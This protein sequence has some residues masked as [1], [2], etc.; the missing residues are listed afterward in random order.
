MKGAPEVLP[1]GGHVMPRCRLLGSVLLATA[2]VA[3]CASAPKREPAQDAGFSS[4]GLKILKETV[5]AEV[6]RGA[7]PGAV[8]L[9]MR[10]GAVALSEAIGVQDPKSGAPMKVDSIFRIA[11]MTKPVVSVGAMVLV[12][13]GEIGLGD[14]VSKYLPE[15][16]GLKVGVE[17]RDTTGALVLEEVPA[18]REMT[19][20]DLL[21][22]T[23]GLTYG[24]FGKSLVKQKYLEA[25]VYGERS[26]INAEQVRR[27]SRLPLAYQPGTTWEYGH[28]TD[29]LGA[30][31]EKV[32]GQTLD[33]YLSERIFKPLRMKDTGFFV[34]PSQQG[35]IA[36]PFDV[37]PDTRS[38]ARVPDVR[39]LPQLLSGG[40]GLV[41][42]AGDYARFAQ[43][44]LN[45]GDLD[46][47][48]I[49]SR[50]TVALM[51]SDRLGPG[52][53]R[54][55]PMFPGPDFGFGFGVAVRTTEGTPSSPGSVG[56]YG[57]IGIYGTY[58][59]V[60]PK[61]KLVAIWMVQRTNLVANMSMNATFRTL[62]FAALE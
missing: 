42:T 45:G 53:S 18:Q 30:L 13:E 38:P 39:T 61:E 17:K 7:Y 50:E 29:V 44:L 41:S 1:S 56:T 62:V 28:S 51:T 43:M 47:V 23:S 5:K 24:Y 14:P 54:T 60:A 27:L 6:V 40:S 49:L 48:R 19:V 3:G 16:K 36:E 46:G 20:E 37:D 59:F 2:L 4:E 52:V 10:N 31:I 8:M 58:F 33:V 55:S 32:S 21:R 35:R 9:V 12:E 11:S 25:K 22:H 57:W 26:Q 15:L 34:E